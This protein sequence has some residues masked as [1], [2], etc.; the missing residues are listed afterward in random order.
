MTLPPN[1]S[2]FS[3]TPPTKPGWYWCKERHWQ[4][5]YDDAKPVEIIVSRDYMCIKDG[6]GYPGAHRVIDDMNALWDPTPIP[7]PG[8]VAKMVEALEEIAEVTTPGDGVANTDWI[9]KRARAVL[10]GR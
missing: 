6:S 9:H 10:E 1:E 3:A 8:E 2:V 4:K 5:G 7:G